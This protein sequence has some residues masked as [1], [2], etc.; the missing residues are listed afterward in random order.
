MRNTR[1][2]LILLVPTLCVGTHVG[3]L[4]VP[5]WRPSRDA[6][7]PGVRSHAERGDGGGLG[8]CMRTPDGSPRR[9]VGAN[10]GLWPGR[11]LQRGGMDE[12]AV[13]AEG[14]GVPRTILAF[15]GDF[16]SRLALYWLVHERGYEV[17]TLSI[18]LGQEVY[19]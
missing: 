1:I 2:W 8:G 4:C 5:P 7:R 3:T 19:L 12:P 15:N 13:T 18:N 14:G 16:E 11:G 17:I 6:E 10:D 9:D